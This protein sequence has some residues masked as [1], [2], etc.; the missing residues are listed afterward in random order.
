MANRTYLTVYLPPTLAQRIEAAARQRGWSVSRL[1]REAVVTYLDGL[2]N[3]TLPQ[4]QTIPGGSP[5]VADE[6]PE[7]APNRVTQTVTG[8]P[9]VASKYLLPSGREVPR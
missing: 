9:I 1:L 5:V 6:D 3:V 2:P 4:P 7:D 8:D